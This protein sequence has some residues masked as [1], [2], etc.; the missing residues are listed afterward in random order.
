[1][2]PANQEALR[3][4]EV[5]LLGEGG[6]SGQLPTESSLVFAV[7]EVCLCALVSQLPTL[8]P[9]PMPSQGRPHHLDITGTLVTS[10]LYMLEQLPNLCSPQGMFFYTNFKPLR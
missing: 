5:A 4:D 7:L 2:V 6:E 9:T 1:M 10:T 8:S 3:Q